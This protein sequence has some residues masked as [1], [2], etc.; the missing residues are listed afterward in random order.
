MKSL[1]HLALSLLA[2]AITSSAVLACDSN[3]TTATTV[4]SGCSAKAMSAKTSKGSACTAEMAAQCTP[5]MREAC[6]KNPAMAAAMGCD[7]S[8]K[9]TTVSAASNGASCPMSG[10]KASKGAA[11]DAHG[12]ATAS[13]DHCA[14]MKTAKAGGDCS[15]GR[16][17]TMTDCSACTD[18]MNGEDEVRVLGG[19]TQVVSLKNG[20]MIVYTAEKD[21][22]VKTLQTAIAKRHDRMSAVFAGSGPQSKLCSDCRAMRG[23]M[24]SGK[25]HREVVNVERGCMTLLTSNDRTIVQRIRAMASSQVALR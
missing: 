10:A 9:G 20:V 11:C 7:P 19:R 17:A 23:A 18:W 8:K 4:S 13:S 21:A 22:D 25:L 6:A 14:G 16:H 5:E 12:T 3:Q 24:A 1:R 2:C 15:M